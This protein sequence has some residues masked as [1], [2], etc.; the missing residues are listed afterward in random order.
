MAVRLVKL[1]SMSEQSR[2]GLDFVSVVLVFLHNINN[3]KTSQINQHQK[4]ETNIGNESVLN[5]V[6]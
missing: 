6:I 1:V 2:P 4:A 3:Y 5:A